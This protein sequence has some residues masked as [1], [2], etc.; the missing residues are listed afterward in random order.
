MDESMI[1]KEIGRYRIVDELGKGGMSVV[2][3]A[4]DTLLERNVAMKM[5]LPNQP[6]EKYKK[7]FQREAKILAQ[8]S[9]PAI[10]KILDYGEFEGKSYIVMEYMAGGTLNACMGKPIPWQDAIN[11]ILP[12]AQALQHA[13]HHKAIHRDVKPSNIL[14]NEAGQP[15]LSDFGIVKLIA[16]DESQSLTGTGSQVGTPHYMAPEQI[17]GQE[18]DPRTDIY[19]LG[20]ILYEMVT[21]KKPY[22]GNTPIEISLKHLNDPVP[23]PRQSLRD[24]PPQVENVIMKA[25]AKKPDDRFRDMGSFIA[26]MQKIIQKQGGSPTRPVVPVSARTDTKEN[27][28]ARKKRPKARVYGVGLGALV[29]VVLAG[30]LV[31][32]Q[33]LLPAERIEEAT[34]VASLAPQTV[35]ATDIPT[36]TLQPA[37]PT[38]EP[39][40]TPTPK[41]TRTA[42]SKNIVPTTTEPVSGNT[43]HRSNLSRVLEINRISMVSVLQLALS[44]DG[45][46]LINAGPK[47]IRIYDPKTVK[48]I[49]LINLENDIPKE[50][51]VTPD[52]QELL[53]MINDTIRRYSLVNRTKLN[54]YTIPRGAISMAIAPN[55]EILGLGMLDSKTILLNASDGSVI[56]TLK[57]NYGGWSIAFS[58]DSAYVASGTS[59]G[60]L[61]WETSSGTWS[62]IDSRQDRLI[63]SLVFSKTGNLLAGGS[64][65]EIYIWSVASGEELIRIKGNFRKVNYLD[66]SPDGM[67]LVGGCDD[68]SVRIWD[69]STGNELVHLPGHKSPVVSSLFSPHGEYI[70][71]GATDEMVIRI[72]GVP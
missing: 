36:A 65:G 53:V 69:S 16:T 22:T 55:G 61:L 70:V 24:I 19:A 23:R 50:I 5:I 39:T 18:I 72:W 59:Q 9:H 31:Y 34:Q 4:V 44:P 47:M 45:K 54:E 33:V 15:M 2:Y 29:F 12:I 49:G 63:N 30:A 52:S 46:Y 21:G 13:H 64:E 25:M 67:L 1:G 41:P 51:V 35:E 11:I 10:V 26:A 38:P 58:P 37:T 32:W 28:E 8:L 43:I 68:N 17:R 48:E 62:P 6:S 3:R 7:R 20:T 14:I 27:E 42:E 71:S 66:F 40:K 56:R 60:V 57:S